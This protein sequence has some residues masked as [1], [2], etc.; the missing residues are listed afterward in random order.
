MSGNLNNCNGSHCRSNGRNGKL[1]AFK[2]VTIY[3]KQRQ[4]NKLMAYLLQFCVVVITFYKYKSF[5]CHHFG[6]PVSLPPK[7]DCRQKYLSD[8]FH[9]CYIYTS[10]F[11]FYSANIYQV[12]LGLAP[13]RPFCHITCYI[14]FVTA[15][16][17]TFFQLL[18][19]SEEKRGL[20]QNPTTFHLSI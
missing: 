19:P 15:F 9:A 16:L 11:L 3:L 18:T 13:E 8:E 7:E 17:A 5:L 1:L 6:R 2:G 4:D 20:L 12:F 14:Y 10:V